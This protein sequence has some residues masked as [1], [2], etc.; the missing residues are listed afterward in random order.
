MQ[1]SSRKNYEAVQTPTQQPKSSY[2]SGNG[3]EIH[4][5]PSHS[6]VKDIRDKPYSYHQPEARQQRTE[7]H[8]HNYNYGH[9]YGW[10]YSQPYYN[11][12]GGYS[13]AFW[14]MLMEWDA[15]RRAQWFYHNQDRIEADAYQR[16]MQDAEVARRVAELKAQGVKPDHN[17]VDKEF[18]DDPSLMMDQEYVDAAYNPPESSVGW[19]VAETLMWTLFGALVVGLVVV[20]IIRK[21]R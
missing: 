14:W 1:E 2:T 8:I 6:T 13:S 4:V 17:Y 5:D 7:V 18:K 11:V 16:G 21:A 15:E 9:P 12:G 10:Y 19:I 3:K 20:V